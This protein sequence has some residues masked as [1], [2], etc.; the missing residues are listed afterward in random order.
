M[1]RGGGLFGSPLHVATVNFDSQMVPWQHHGRTS[2][3][4]R[5][6][7]VLIE[8]MLLIRGKADVNQTDADGRA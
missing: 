5:V 2:R 3:D 1:N 8:V 7:L 4:R 6:L